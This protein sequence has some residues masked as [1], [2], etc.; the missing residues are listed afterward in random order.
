LIFQEKS[1][2]QCK[3]MLSRHETLQGFSERLARLIQRESGRAKKQ[4]FARK[5]GV[6]PQQL[7]RYLKG[8]VPD[9]LTLL[10]IAE[11]GQVSVDW[12]LTGREVRSGAAGA[13]YPSSLGTLRRLAQ[14]PAPV[15]LVL[16]RV[17]DELETL[18]IWEQLF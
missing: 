10:A 18:G 2:C 8:Q 16:L 15:V 9:V 13:A 17:V 11:V 5:I 6:K 7:S 3:I 12:L 14:L 1:I 4:A